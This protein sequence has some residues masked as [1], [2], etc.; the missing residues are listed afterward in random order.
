MKKD[1]NIGK[2]FKKRDQDHPQL[3]ND[4][5]VD[6]DMVQIPGGRASTKST[7]HHSLSDHFKYHFFSSNKTHRINYTE[8]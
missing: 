4:Y 8:E 2:S 1:Y 5:Q 6:L 7:R 3:T